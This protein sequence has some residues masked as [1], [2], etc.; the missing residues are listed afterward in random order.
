MKQGILY[1]FL[2]LALANLCWAGSN[3]A[4]LV[5]AKHHAQ[6]HHA[7]KAAKHRA[8]KRHHRTV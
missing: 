8:P 4:A 2:S 7:H 1:L 3:Q 5:L 6:H